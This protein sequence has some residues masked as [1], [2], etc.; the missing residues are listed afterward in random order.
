MPDQS[1]RRRHIGLGIVAGLVVAALITI[2]ALG[3]FQY[4]RSQ[5]I[6]MPYGAPIDTGMM[7]YLPESA[8]VTYHALATE[9]PWEIVL[10]MQVRNPQTE[11]LEPFVD[12]AR[13]VLGVD[14]L[15]RL[16]VEG[17]AY[18]LHWDAPAEEG[19][20]FISRK[21]VPPESDWMHMHMR[22]RADESFE[23]GSTYIVALRLM[24][25]RT[26]AAYGYSDA[27]SWAAN[28]YARIYTVEVPLTRLPDKEY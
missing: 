9:K 2:A 27:K 7:V 10:S 22:L 11:A 13:S 18:S 5:T 6:V 1:L 17:S 16:V 3:G 8:T 20:K 12:I 4:R 28:K 15:S 23:P 14:P 19:Y 24:E 25:F 26:T 21:P